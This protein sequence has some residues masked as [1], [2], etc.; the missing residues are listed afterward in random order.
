MAFYFVLRI[1]SLF[2]VFFMD[3]VQADLQTTCSAVTTA[4]WTYFYDG[5][6]YTAHGSSIDWTMNYFEAAQSCNDIPGLEGHLAVMPDDFANLFPYMAYVF[7]SVCF[8]GPLGVLAGA[9]AG[10]AWGRKRFPVW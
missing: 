2:S 4:Q 7:V 8:I 5:S 3:R 10:G 6:C 9:C 1:V